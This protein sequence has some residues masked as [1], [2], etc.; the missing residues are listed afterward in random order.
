MYNNWLDL[1]GKVKEFNMIF[2]NGGYYEK[3]GFYKR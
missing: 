2:G 1:I 3:G